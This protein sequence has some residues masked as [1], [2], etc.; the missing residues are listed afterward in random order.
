MYIKDV[1]TTC[2]LLGSFLLCLG[3]CASPGVYVTNLIGLHEGANEMGLVAELLP[4]ASD[5]SLDEEML[6][7]V[8]GAAMH[9]GASAEA[10]QWLGS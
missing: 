6:A 10:A 8:F 9:T 7:L 2:F 4:H 3:S 1:C 5:E